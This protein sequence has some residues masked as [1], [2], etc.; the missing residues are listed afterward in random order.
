MDKTA[1]VRHSINEGHEI[2][3]KNTSIMEG[4]AVIEID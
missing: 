2:M 1:V 3:L 4:A